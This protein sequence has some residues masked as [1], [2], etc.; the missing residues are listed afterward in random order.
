MLRPRQPALPGALTRERLIKLRSQVS[1][2]GRAK[3]RGRLLGD[4][5]TS[6]CPWRARHPELLPPRA[7]A[8][9]RRWETGHPLLRA[10]RHHTHPLR[11]SRRRSPWEQPSPKLSE[12]KEDGGVCRKTTHSS[13]WQPGGDSGSSTLEEEEEEVEEEEVKEEEGEEEE[14]E[15]QKEKDENSIMNETDQQQSYSWV[16]RNFTLFISCIS[17]IQAGILHDPVSIEVPKKNY[18]GQQIQFLSQSNA[19]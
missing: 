9:A 3:G 13:V 17:L 1:T 16:W 12:R 19:L 8:R 14:E 10:Q 2:A 11:P 7:R 15:E 18:K 5:K 6:P 4:D